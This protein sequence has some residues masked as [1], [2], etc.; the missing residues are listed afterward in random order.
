[1]N[2]ILEGI[3]NKLP[4]LATGAEG[5]KQAINLIPSVVESGL[6]VVKEGQ[7]A[8]DRIH[9]MVG[10][11][12]KLPG[13]LEDLNRARAKLDAVASAVEAAGEK[14]RPEG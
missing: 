7:E 14:Y 11:F 6:A 1:M 12:I 4:G 8:F 10:K 2:A 5:V 3:I 9:E 13:G